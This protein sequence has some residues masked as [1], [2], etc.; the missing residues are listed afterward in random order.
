MHV[1]SLVLPF[2]LYLISEGVVNTCLLQKTHKVIS[3]FSI[4][5]SGY[6]ITIDQ[7][8]LTAV[9]CLAAQY[10]RLGAVSTKYQLVSNCALSDCERIP[11]EG[12]LAS[13]SNC[14]LLLNACIYC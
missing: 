6:G 12:D 1:F 7:A 8:A 11:H 2:T 13:E 3:L 14:N 10:H 5:S 9:D 4:H